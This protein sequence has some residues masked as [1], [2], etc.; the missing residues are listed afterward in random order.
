MRQVFAT[1][2]DDVIYA[3]S[4]QNIRR[5]LS[6]HQRPGAVVYIREGLNKRSL[7]FDEFVRRVP[8]RA[9]DKATNVDS[10]SRRRVWGVVN[11]ENKEGTIRS[12]ETESGEGLSTFPRIP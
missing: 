6:T 4:I 10:A 9:P 8:K 5:V 12:L 11:G 7:A 1:C 2:P 3:S